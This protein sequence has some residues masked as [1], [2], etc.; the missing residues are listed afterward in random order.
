MFHYLFTNDLRISNLEAFLKD[1]GRCFAND[2]VPSAAQDK[3]A[4]NNMNTLG[5]YFNLTKE[6]KCAKEC[7]NGNIRKVVLNF[8]KKFQFPNPR[9]TESL[10]QAIDDQITL[11]PMRV[12]LQALYLLN[13]VDPQNAFLTKEEIAEYI[14]F[15]EDVAKSIQPDIVGMVNKIING[16]KSGDNP[17][18]PSDV[19]LENRGCYWKQSKRQVRE[20]VKVLCWSGCVMENDNGS[21]KIH[22][23][24]LS[25]D[26]EADLFEILTYKGRWIPDKTKSLNEN[27]TSYQKYM[28]VD[29]VS[30]SRDKVD[31]DEYQRAAEYVKEYM[32]ETGFQFEESADEIRQFYDEFQN[33]FSVDKLKNIPD[34]KLLSE[35]F[36][37]AESTNDSLCYWL[38]FN[39]QSRNFGGGIA[40]GSSYK[41]GLFQRKDDNVWIS[42][43][44]NKPLE[45]SDEDALELGK[46]I[47]DALVNGASI[48]ADGDL[49]T[50]EDYE[51]LDDRLNSAIGKYATMGWIHK[52]FYLLYPDKLSAYHSTDWQKHILFSLRIKPSAKYYGRSGQ[53]SIVRRYLNLEYRHFFEV[54]YDKF[55]GIKKFCRLGTSDRKI[56]Y[57]E[58][59]CD[60]NIVAVGWNEL[61][62]LEDYVVA[63]EISRKA[64][65]EKMIDV[66]YPGDTKT[67]SR[68]AGEVATFF[69][70]NTDTVFVAMNG[71]TPLALVDEIGKYYYDV[72]SPMAHRKSGQWHKCF[73]QEEKLPNQSAGHMTT[74]YELNDDENLAYL[75]EKYFYNSGE[76]NDE[77]EVKDEVKEY[78]PIKF[79]TDLETEFE[80]NRIVFGA[81][82]TGKS[83]RLKE[84]SGKLLESTTGTLERVTFHPDYTYSQFVGTYKPVSD[85]N[86]DIRYKFVP[87]PFMRIYVDALKSGRTDEPQPHLLLV[88]EINRARVAA[89]FGDI[90]QLLDRNSVGV[91]EYDIQAT[92]DIRKYLAEELGGT[93]ENYEKLQLPNNLFIWATMNSADQGVFPMDTAFKRRW[94]FQYIGI[95]DSQD[96]LKYEDGREYIIPVGMKEN[97]K[98]VKWNDLR[99]G[100][101]EILTDTC[102]VNE[103]KLLGP[104]FM[105]KD[106]LENAVSTDKKEDKF[107]EAFESKVIM[108]LFEDVMKM[109]PEKIFKGHFENQGKKIYSEI[110]NTFENDGIGVFGLDINVSD[111]KEFN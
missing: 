4:N 100:I 70:S 9:T 26:N 76:N 90:F 107:V 106:M 93:K 99:T 111:T 13:M 92:E 81:P 1:A 8:I 94:N 7:E 91:S 51:K 50:L 24:T 33:R 36:Y 5:F 38:E 40:G 77:K 85:A 101:N 55:G 2:C 3:N 42:G 80:R 73:E 88:E 46:N 87:G 109:S 37:S 41:F 30:S 47:R 69:R 34:D 20:M 105:S 110:C 61:G 60:K 98:Y 21:I 11:A 68:K 64:I 10:N 54:V 25:R 43:S 12:I 31:V 103:D 79:E 53:I 17:I 57:A 75:Y 89:V 28:D 49:N 59:W 66:F 15:G 72:D 97:R 63:N 102:K 52:Y 14:F 74:C 67:A 86:G 22:H 23:E 39:Q 56:N 32:L 82:G 108:Y 18:F 35:L 104:F 6:S 29:A 71:D 48:I 44:P 58:E 78:I 96:K 65:T 84:D 45:L 27:K 19:E 95:N 16:R 62:S 83:F